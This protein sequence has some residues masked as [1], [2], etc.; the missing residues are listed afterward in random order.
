MMEAGIIAL[1]F[2]GIAALVGLGLTVFWIWMLIEVVTKEPEQGNG[3]IVWVLI[4][5][6]TG[7]IGAAIY[8]FVRRPSRISETGK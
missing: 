1:L 2:W 7:W 8:F 4:I 6:L 3:K 5:A